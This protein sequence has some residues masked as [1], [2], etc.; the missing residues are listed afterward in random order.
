MSSPLFIAL[1][2]YQNKEISLDEFTQ[3]IEAQ[4]TLQN[5]LWS[6]ESNESM[7][8]WS[9]K[10]VNSEIQF[11]CALTKSNDPY[12]LEWLYNKCISG[13][14]NFYG[15]NLLIIAIE[16]SDEILLNYLHQ[17]NPEKLK[18]L[19]LAT[20]NEGLYPLHI[21]VNEGFIEITDILLSAGADVNQQAD[22][23][24]GDTPLISAVHTNNTNMVNHLLARGASVHQ[25][26]KKGFYPLHIAAENGFIEITGIL[27]SAGA[28][29]NQQEDSEW[30]DTPH[31]QSSTAT[32]P[33][34]ASP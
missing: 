26:N 23:E 21:A 24:W 15:D 28:D 6:G 13:Y 8:V 30:G 11:L 29:V 3:Q 1:K 33:F 10:E 22:S 19:V 34:S 9:A 4:L 12:L 27:L 2:Q 14:T 5:Q 25:C 7:P 31:I 17:R 16:R 20:S 18:E 32:T